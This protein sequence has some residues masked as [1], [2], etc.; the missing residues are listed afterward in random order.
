M[1]LL[2]TGANGMLGQRVVAEARARAYAAL[3]RIR[4][5]G[6]HHRTDIA[7]GI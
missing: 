2:V 4:M 7:A 1:R 5:R 6:G 3:G